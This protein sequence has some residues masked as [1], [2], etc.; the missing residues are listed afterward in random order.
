MSN[1]KPPEGKGEVA[2]AAFAHVLDAE[3]AVE[4]AVALCRKEADRR[5]AEA[6][7]NERCLTERVE[8]RILLWR[9][10]LKEAAAGQI[11]EL[12]RQAAQLAAPP[13]LDAAA[14][15]RISL[16]ARRVADQLLAGD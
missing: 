1:K 5:L 9:A 8:A 15:E 14:Q 3:R 11:A 4:E 13:A 12:D 10:R 2:A 7:A 16:A 6:D